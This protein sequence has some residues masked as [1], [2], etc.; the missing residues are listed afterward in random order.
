MIGSKSR[1][2]LDNIRDDANT[3]LQEARTGVSEIQRT[4]GVFLA[5]FALIATCAV[6][7]LLL[8]SIALVR[9]SCTDR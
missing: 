8:S 1:A 5:T 3:L 6:A 2:A 7:A 9:Q 4:S